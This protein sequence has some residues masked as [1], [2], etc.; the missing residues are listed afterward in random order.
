M[1]RL[2]MRLS[3]EVIF[4]G[5]PDRALSLKVPGWACLHF[6]RSL[7]LALSLSVSLSLSIQRLIVQ[8]LKR[9]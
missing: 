1:E 8:R 2:V 9:A 5:Q 6:L 7:S 4:R 3:F